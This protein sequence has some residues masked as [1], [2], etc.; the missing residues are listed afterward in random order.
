MGPDGVV[1]RSKAKAAASTATGSSSTSP[2]TPTTP[3]TVAQPMTQPASAASSQPATTP[4]LPTS[5]GLGIQPIRQDKPNSCW[6]ASGKMVYQSY[7]GVPLGDSQ[8]QLAKKVGVKDLDTCQPIV[9]VLKKLKVEAAEDKDDYI[10]TPMEY[11]SALS[12]G[13]PLVLTVSP[14]AQVRQGRASRASGAPR[15]GTYVSNAKQSITEAHY[16]VVSGYK[17]DKL[18]V[19][20]PAQ[21]NA[22]EVA[23]PPRK[24]TSPQGQPVY[25]DPPTIAVGKHRYTVL[26]TYYTSNAGI[27]PSAAS[28]ST[29]SSSGKQ[30]VKRKASQ[31]SAS[32]TP[33]ASGRNVRSKPS[34]P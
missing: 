9:T 18:V 20:D 14:Q 2:S 28:Q 1:T 3:S 10:P 15:K 29:S 26:T 16:M 30:G 27:T 34:I 17:D 23:L 33:A 21:P 4:Q 13:E 7:A 24:A 25:A 32:A 8:V 31:I 6:A 5:H 22:H 19:I 11:K 12:A